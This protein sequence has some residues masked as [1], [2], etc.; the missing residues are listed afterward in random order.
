MQ[1][2]N[3]M[4]NDLL[5]HAMTRSLCFDSLFVLSKIFCCMSVY[6]YLSASGC[7][8]ETPKS[9]T[10]PGATAPWCLVYSTYTLHTA[11]VRGINAPLC[12]LFVLYASFSGLFLLYVVLFLVWECAC[13]QRP[14]VDWIGLLRM[15]NPGMNISPTY[16][17][18]RKK[19]HTYTFTHTYGMLEISSIQYAPYSIKHTRYSMQHTANYSLQHT[20]YSIQHTAYSLQHAAYSIQHTT[21]NI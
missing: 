14:L 20:A 3:S 15:K 1:T 11:A 12:F 18:R 21:Y 9:S 19:Q 6:E 8:R 5:K 10:S 13:T 17:T 4:A 16:I 7:C 2:H